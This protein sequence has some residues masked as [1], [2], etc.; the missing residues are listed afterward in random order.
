MNTVNNASVL[1]QKRARHTE[2][3][4]STNGNIS[5]VPLGT[6]QRSLLVLPDDCLV[7]IANRLTLKKLSVFTRTCKVVHSIFSDDVLFCKKWFSRFE[8]QQQALFSKVA[9][10]ITEKEL[11]AWVG[12]FS[13]NNGEQKEQIVADLMKKHEAIYFTDFL[14][15]KICRLMTAAYSGIT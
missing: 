7:N 5:V 1:Y 2:G 11:R 14:F 10:G 9:K 6:V 8:P 15:F 13:N 12:Q 3:E 4:E